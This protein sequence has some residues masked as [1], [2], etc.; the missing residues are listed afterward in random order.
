[1]KLDLEFLGIPAYTQGF[2]AQKILRNSQKFLGILGVNRFN[3]MSSINI[4]CQDSKV[5]ANLM[6]NYQLEKA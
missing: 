6:I 1:M 5:Y 3:I 2:R 4:Q